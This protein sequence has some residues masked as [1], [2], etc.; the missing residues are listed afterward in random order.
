MKCDG[1]EGDATYHSQVAGLFPP[2]AV[3]FGRPAALDGAAAPCGSLA[4]R[5]RAA[6]A[7]VWKLSCA[8]TPTCACRCCGGCARS[9]CSAD[10][11][12][13]AVG[14]GRTRTVCRGVRRR[15][16]CGAGA[17][18]GAQQRSEVDQQAARVH[19]AAV[20]LIEF[21]V[22]C[23]TRGVRARVRVCHTQVSV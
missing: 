18:C 2:A 11:G 3:A 23:G 4:A 17:S 10:E 8:C 6:A 12:D 1:R 20:P 15:R 19:D 14:A 9:L 21:G 13:L 7:T 16:G 5:A 22:V